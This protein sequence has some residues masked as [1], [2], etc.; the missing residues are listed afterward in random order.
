MHFDEA[1]DTLVILAPRII[2]DFRKICC[3]KSSPLWSQGV[4]PLVKLFEPSDLNV[5]T[6]STTAT[7]SGRRISD[8]LE[9][10]T[11]QF[12]GVVNTAA[13]K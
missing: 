5:E 12:H 1:K 9:L 11:D 4:G 13:F 2:V 10:T 8:N 6:G 3:W 7:A